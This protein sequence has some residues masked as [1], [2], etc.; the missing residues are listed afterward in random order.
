MH[1]VRN[2]SKFSAVVFLAVLAISC[3]GGGGGDSV[4]IP[5]GTV[6][7]AGEGELPA[8]QTLDYTTDQQKT[9]V[10]INMDTTGSMGGE[11]SNL[12]S[13]FQN[14]VP[15]LQIKVPDI[16]F[17]A[18]DYEDYPYATDFGEPGDQPFRLFQRISTDATATQAGLNAM[19]L[20]NGGD[21]PESGWEAL[22][23]IA[24]G[25]G[26][27]AGGSYV[28]PFDPS[29][30]TQPDGVEWG[31]LGGVGFR[32]GAL[33]LVIWVTDAGNHNTFPFGGAATQAQAVAALN[34]LH[35]RVIGVQAESDADAFADL[36][37]T[38]VDTGAIVPVTAWGEVGVRPAGCAAD[39]CCTGL[40][41]AGVAAESGLCPLVFHISGDGTGLGDAITTGITKLLDSQ[42]MDVT[43]V[44][45]DDS[46]DSVD[47]VAAFID[48]AE[49][50]TSAGGDC[51]S[52]LA[53]IDSDT[54]GTNDTFLDV[55]GGQTVCFT[56][57][58]RTNDTVSATSKTQV[59]KVTLALY[60][61]HVTLLYEE[62][63]YFVVPSAN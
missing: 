7:Y 53:V 16:A 38:A 12:R 20:G 45:V 34:S 56:I 33:P 4:E 15:A 2:L 36:H 8:P 59:Y 25:A 13:S 40:N 6:F 47:A 50:D 58:P 46:S 3:G 37:D 28:P 10:F 31:T 48:S 32:V 62:D 63:L 52:G 1:L 22:Y 51:A 18:G 57:H 35:A 5:E 54:D 55:P 9:D 11:L 60:G 43:A 14:I 49:A 42:T 29:S 44:L 39:Q 17:G 30:G 19:A 26:V 24:T 41:G 21:L 27:T 61:D 23:Q